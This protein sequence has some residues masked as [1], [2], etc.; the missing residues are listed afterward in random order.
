MVH[1]R[2]R[3]KWTVSPN[4]K[5]TFPLSAFVSSWK[6]LISILWMQVSYQILLKPW[7]FGALRNGDCYF[8]LSRQSLPCNWQPNL[9]SVIYITFIY[10]C[11]YP[12]KILVQNTQKDHE[13]V[14]THLSPLQESVCKNNWTH[15]LWSR[16][17]FHRVPWIS[18]KWVKQLPGRQ[19][20][21]QELVK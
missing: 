12:T 11:F 4:I 5:V 16:D 14:S 13:G 7:N 9:D 2:K 20:A 17:V 10:H 8:C 19:T 3:G 1:M 21:T 18:P 15:V 6:G